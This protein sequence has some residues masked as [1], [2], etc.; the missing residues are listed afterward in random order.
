MCIK[1]TTQIQGNSALLKHSANR[2][3]QNH[4]NEVSVLLCIYTAVKSR[5]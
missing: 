1:K 5:V 2:I 3:V 4:F